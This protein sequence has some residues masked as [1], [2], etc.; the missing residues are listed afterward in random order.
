LKD[1]CQRLCN[2]SAAGPI[3]ERAPPFT[4]VRPSCGHGSWRSE[5]RC[6]SDPGAQRQPRA[7]LGACR[8]LGDDNVEI[9]QQQ[10]CAVDGSLSARAWIECQRVASRREVSQSNGGMVGALLKERLSESGS[11]TVS[12]T[13]TSAASRSSIAGTMAS[14]SSIASTMASSST[15]ASPVADLPIRHGSWL[16]GHDGANSVEQQASL[17]EGHASSLESLTRVLQRAGFALKAAEHFEACADDWLEVEEGCFRD[18]EIPVIDC[19]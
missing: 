12:S 7:F 16:R 9:L 6:P 17:S 8:P 10:E 1:G 14:R 11:T 13:P 4:A 5:L 2:S 3:T 15:I 18:D 19:S